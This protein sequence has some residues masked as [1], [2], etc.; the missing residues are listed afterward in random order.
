VAEKGES[1]LALYEK[2]QKEI[3]LVLLD[4]IMP[5]MGEN[6]AWRNFCAEI[7]L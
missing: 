2:G 5:G 6:G 3:S 7:L 4:L 1:A